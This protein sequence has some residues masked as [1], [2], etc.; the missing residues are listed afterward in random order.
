MKAWFPVARQSPLPAAEPT[1]D[2]DAT[3]SRRPSPCPSETADRPTVCST[4]GRTRD[5][6]A[7]DTGISVDPVYFPGLP[8]VVRERLFGL[9]GV[10]GDAPDGKSHQDGF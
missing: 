3:P 6:L 7:L 9:S 8:A 10:G 1:N 5:R 4:N 2:R